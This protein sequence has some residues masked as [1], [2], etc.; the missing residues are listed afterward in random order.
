[1]AWLYFCSDGG[2]G[3]LVVL[4]WCVYTMGWLRCSGGGGGGGG[5]GGDMDLLLLLWLWWLGCVVVVVVVWLSCG[6]GGRDMVVLWW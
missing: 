5:G 4:R 3:G 6:D 1:M 2:D